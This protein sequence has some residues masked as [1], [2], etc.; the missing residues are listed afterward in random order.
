MP[1]YETLKLKLI[2]SALVLIEP[3]KQRILCVRL[4][5]SYLEKGS[6]DLLHTWWVCC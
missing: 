1:K 2:K 3:K 5:F 4:L 6:S